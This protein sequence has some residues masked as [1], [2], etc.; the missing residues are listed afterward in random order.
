ME[1]EQLKLE[2]ADIINQKGKT[3]VNTQEVVCINKLI[4]LSPLMAY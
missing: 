2:K 1:I 3:Q 4:F